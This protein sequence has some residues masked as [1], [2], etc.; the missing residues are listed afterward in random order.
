[1]ESLSRGVDA[2]VFDQ[3]DMVYIRDRMTYEIS[4]GKLWDDSDS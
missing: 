3:Q 2:F 1:M 4:R